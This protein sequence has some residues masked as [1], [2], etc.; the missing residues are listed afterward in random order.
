MYSDIPLDIKWEVRTLSRS[1][2]IEFE[3]GHHKTTNKFSS[4]ALDLYKTHYIDYIRRIKIL[5][6]GCARTYTHPE[7]TAFCIPD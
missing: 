2:D 6:Q 7:F 1:R 5:V 4:D 3:A